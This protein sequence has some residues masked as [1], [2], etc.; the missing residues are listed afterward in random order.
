MVSCG[1]FLRHFSDYRDGYLDPADHAAMREHAE[2]CASCSRYERA[3]ELGVGELKALPRIEPSYDFIQRLQH[4]LYHI[5]EERAARR[6]DRS[7]VSSGF[8]LALVLLISAAAWVPLAKQR[9]AVVEMPAVLAV[10]PKEDDTVPSLFREGPLL[11]REERPMMLISSR[12]LVLD[13]SIRLSS[14][15]SSSYRPGLA[16][17]R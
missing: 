8:V 4:R 13:G 15:A 17:P 16:R 7:A 1:D 3:L 5:D 9:T 14:Y 6:G 10:A 11:L 12:P 2:T